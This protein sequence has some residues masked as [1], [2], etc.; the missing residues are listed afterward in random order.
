MT[1]LTPHTKLAI[2]APSP[3]QLPH[4]IREA[5]RVAFWG[6]PGATAVV[7]SGDFVKYKF[8]RHELDDLVHPRG[9]LAVKAVG[10]APKPA[11]DRDRVKHLAKLLM[12]GARKPLLV[13]GKGAAYSRCEEMVRIFVKR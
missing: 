1:F 5:Y 11:G 6:R 8:D 9:N 13:V 4:A 2:Q 10:P 7:I 12:N 3:T